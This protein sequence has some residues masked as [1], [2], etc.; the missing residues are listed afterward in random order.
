MTGRSL[1]EAAASLHDNDDQR[2]VFELEGSRKLKVNLNGTVWV[3]TGTVVSFAGEVELQR[4]SVREQGLGRLL[5]KTLSGQ[6]VRLTRATG[7]G[8]LYLSDHNK[9]VQ[10]VHLQ[11]ESTFVNGRDLL[12]FESTI[13]WDIRLT[14]QLTAIPSAGLFRVKLQGTG[15]IALTTPFE[16]LKLPL[17]PGLLQTDP[18]ASVA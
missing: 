7:Q 9:N 13:T 18:N 15:L 17:R 4:A 1:K 16:L 5:K 10:I 3:T 11:D 12:A 8:C 6:A 2:D 14:K